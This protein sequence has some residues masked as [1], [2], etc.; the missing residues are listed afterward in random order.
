MIYHTIWVSL[1][2]INTFENCLKWVVHINTLQS[3]CIASI[4]MESCSNFCV[5]YYQPC[6]LRTETGSLKPC[7]V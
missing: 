4:R 1:Y 3:P 2:D 6:I 5:S 7:I